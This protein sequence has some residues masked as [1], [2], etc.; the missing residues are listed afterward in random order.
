MTEPTYIEQVW[1][2]IAVCICMGLSIL[3]I[4][5]LP[6][7]FGLLRAKLNEKVR[8]RMEQRRQINKDK[9]LNGSK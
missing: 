8:E 4:V 2:F 5:V 9:F 1:L 7:A 6:G 3:F